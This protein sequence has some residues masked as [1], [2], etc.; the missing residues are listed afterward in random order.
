MPTKTTENPPPKA[1]PSIRDQLDHWFT[2]HPPTPETEPKYAAITLARQEAEAVVLAEGSGRNP[3]NFERVGAAL[4]NLAIVILNNAP[5]CADTTAAI[6]CV[7]LARNAAN[8]LLRSPGD[9][10]LQAIAIQNLYSAQW[11]A[12]SAVALD[13]R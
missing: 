10:Q 2:Y 12:N 5:A 6:R 3:P 4:K 7:R 11:Q 13:G 1:S 8:A 9:G